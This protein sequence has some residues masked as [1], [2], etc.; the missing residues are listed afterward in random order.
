MD[1]LRRQV[2]VGMTLVLHMGM[3]RDLT[4]L[5][6]QCMVLGMEQ[7]D[8]HHHRH[9]AEEVQEVTSDVVN[10]FRIN[11]LEF[12]RNDFYRIFRIRRI[13]FSVILKIN[14]LQI[15]DLQNIIFSNFEN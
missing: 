7:E 12:F 5:I 2:E 4:H 10:F 15:L 3:I 6:H 13:L 8:L 11:A 9:K 14:I 1:T